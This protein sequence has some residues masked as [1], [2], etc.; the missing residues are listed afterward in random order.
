[1]PRAILSVSDKTGIVD[2]GRGL[3]ARGFELISTGGTARALS[4]AGLAVIHVSDVTGF[5]EM[6]DGRVKTL[7]PAIHGGILARRDRPDDLAAIAAR[8]RP[9]D[10]RR[11]QPVSVREGGGQ[12][13][14]AVRRLVEEIDIGG[15]SMVR[16]AAKNFRDVL[17][18]VQPLDYPRLLTALDEGPSLAF[19]YELMVKAF[20]HTAEYDATIARRCCSR[21]SR[22]IGG[23][24]AQ[25]RHS[26]SGRRSSSATP[27][28]CRCASCE[29]CATAKTRT[30]R[31]RGT[32]ERSAGRAVHDPAGEG[33]VVHQPA[34][35]STRRRGS[36]WSSPSPPRW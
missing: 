31:P 22:A 26:L 14:D 28:T 19:R 9:V 29:I 27:S 4:D 20:A 30:R 1:M 17:V 10:C 3:A 32:S 25:R 34:R 6:M 33:A 5:P 2:L 18:V 24:R 35:L 36:C 13:R 11:R 7:H 15:P 8:H 21:R 23:A 16:A 12:S